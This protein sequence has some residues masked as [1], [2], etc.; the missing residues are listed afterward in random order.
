VA[1]PG[2]PAWLGQDIV[3][4]HGTTDVHVQDVL[5]AVDETRGNPNKDFGRG[6]YTTTREDKAL[7]W[8]INKAQV[9]GGNAAVVRFAVER[10]DLADLETLFFVRGEPN[11]ADFWS[12]V[13]YCRT[14]GVGGGHNRLYVAGWYDLVVG[15]VTGTWKRQTVIADTDQISFHTLRAVG[16]LNNSAKVRTV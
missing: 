16:V 3:L 7:D 9:A 4:Y 13:Q 12:F 15:P 1:L 6:F 5:Q 10:D 14:V 11:A 2:I 8:A